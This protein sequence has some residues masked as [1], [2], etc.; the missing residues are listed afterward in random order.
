MSAGIVIFLCATALSGLF[1]AFVT[2]CFQFKFNVDH[3]LTALLHA[4][5]PA[6]LI[7]SPSLS[8]FVFVFLHRLSLHN[9]L[10][11]TIIHSPLIIRNCNNHGDMLLLRVSA[12]VGRLGVNFF[13]SLHEIITGAADII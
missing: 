3:L 10:L 6:A 1:A 13:D 9:V 8:G 4:C 2:F 5:H 12:G 7:L 11:F